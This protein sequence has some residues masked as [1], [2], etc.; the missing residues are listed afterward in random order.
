[1]MLFDKWDL[2]NLE[3]LEKY[4]KVLEFHFAV[5]VRTILS[6]QFLEHFIVFV[7]IN[8]TEL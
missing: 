5:S 4:L 7:V 2:W 1:M 6:F 3:L 8:W